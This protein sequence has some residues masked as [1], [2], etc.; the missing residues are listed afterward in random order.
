[1]NTFN[2]TKSNTLLIKT[3]ISLD[4]NYVCCQIDDKIIIDYNYDHSII[5]PKEVKQDIETKIKNIDKKCVKK[6]IEDNNITK[7]LLNIYLNNEKKQEE[8]WTIR[9]F[10]TYLD[11][12]IKEAK[13]N[14]SLINGTLFWVFFIFGLP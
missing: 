4:N 9:E 12:S 10:F 14:I 3:N 6:I 11:L 7:I 8:I 5:S 2:K 13:N 1:M